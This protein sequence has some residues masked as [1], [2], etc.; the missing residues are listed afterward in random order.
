MCTLQV[1][2]GRRSSGSGTTGVVV[3][4]GVWRRPDET[5]GDCTFDLVWLGDKARMR[6]GFGLR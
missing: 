6:C 5:F 3:V 2:A 4:V 1:Q